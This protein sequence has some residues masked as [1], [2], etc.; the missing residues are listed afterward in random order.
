MKKKGLTLLTMSLLVLTGC[1]GG[2][3]ASGSAKRVLKFEFLKAGFGTEP[4][5]ALANAFMAEH[6]DVTVKL[7]PNK[8]INSTT[9]TKLQANNNLSDIYSVRSVSYIKSWAAKGYVHAL[10]GLLDEDLGDGSTIRSSL[11]ADAMDNAEYNGKHYSVPEY[12]SVH[13]FVY[14]AGMFEQ[15][16]WKIPTTTHELELLCKQITSDTSGKVAP[17]VYCG[18]AADG[19]LYYGIDGWMTSY[20]GL[21]NMKAFYSYDSPERW[22]PTSSISQGKRYGM[23]NLKKFFFGDYAMSKSMG[24][25]HIEAQTNILKGEAAMMV[26]GAWFESEMAAALKYYPDLKLKMM[27]VPEVSDDANTILHA[28]GY[29][30]EDG[31]SVLSSEYGASY[32]IPEHAG[33]VSDAEAFLKFLSRKDICQLYTSKTYAPRP[34]TYSLD[35]S[36]SVYANVDDFGK[37]VLAMAKDNVLYIPYSKSLLDV[38]GYVSLYPN[39]PGGYWNYKQYSDPNTYT[40]DYCLQQD[41]QY[42]SDNWTRWQGLIGA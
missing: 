28:D 6:P 26:N 17:I 36:E 7:V 42:V 39:A 3:G 1:G 31:K 33:N 32:F 4:Y 24:K 2:S 35:T 27:A 12:T 5:E 22:S 29:T 23:D 41:Y 10:D 11:S 30:T 14:N 20:E 18:A 8:D 15:Y 25:T 19:Y 37:S 38:Y 13:G 16:G 40:D 9:A 21:A 34:F